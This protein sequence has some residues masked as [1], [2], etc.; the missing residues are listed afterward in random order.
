MSHLRSLAIV[1]GLLVAWP[2]AGEQ[3]AA[4]RLPLA[5][6]WLVKSSVLVAEEGATVSTPTFQP[7]G[8]YP[9]T[10]PA[11]VLSTLIRA[12]V[13]P[14]LRV[15]MNSFKIPDA[16]D[17]FN[18]QHDLGQYSYLPDRRNPW[19]D[20]YW[21]RT[22]FTLPATARGH[23][24]W[25]CFD[26]IHYRADVWL[27][28]HPVATRE[29]VVGAFQ[30]YRFDVTDVARFDG[31]NCLA[32]KIH[33]MDHPGTP[34]TQL[35]PL[36]R[37]RKY[38]KEGMKDVGL[39]M[40]IGYDCMPTVPDRNMGLWQAVYLELG[41][42]VT[43]RDP[44]VVTRLPLPRTDSA[45]LT[46]T[47]E[48]VNATATAQQGLLRGTIEETGG[49][50]EQPITLGPHESRVVRLT[51]DDCPALRLDKPR[52]WWPVNY[53]PQPLYHLQLE[54]ET[55]GR[56]LEQRRVT[57]GVREVRRELHTLD[58]AH[59]LRV[60]VNGQRIFCR[61][62]YLQPEILFDWDARRM[63]TEIRYLTSANINLVYFE[64]IPCPPDLLLD[65]CDRYGLMFGNCFYGCYW[66]MPGKPYPEDLELLG[67]G[68]ADII[69]R[70]RNH[71]SLVL[72]MAM[73]EG[74]TSEKVYTQWRRLITEH[75]GTR[76]WIPSGS[77]PDYRKDVAPWIKPD[78]PVGMN[79][80]PPKS[81]GW[82]GPAQ[83]FRWVREERNWMFMLESGCPAPPP[84]DSLQ[85]FLPDFDQ[86]PA[87][88]LYPLT[89]A[90]AHHDA[91]HYFKPFDAA[92]R[93]LL[94]TPRNVEDYLMKSLLLTA[95]E[96]RGLFEAANHRM[97]DIT[98]GFSEWKLNACWPCVEWQLYDWYLRPLVSYYYVKKAC[99][100]LHVQL[101]PLD[102][103]VTVVNNRLAPQPGLTVQ[104]RVYDFESRLRWDKTARLD[105]PANAYREVFAVPEALRLA[106]VFFVDLKLKD[107]A[108]RVVSDNFYWLAGRE[109]ADLTRIAQLAPVELRTTC[110]VD[111][112]GQECVARVRVKNPTDRLAFFV[113]LALTKGPGGEEVLPVWWDDNY[114]SLPPGASK[115]LC[116][117]FAAA[118]LGAAPATLELGGWNVATR[119]DCR[120]VQLSKAAVGPGEPVTVTATI[121]NTFL[122]GSRIGLYVDDRPTDAQWFWARG[123][124]ARDLQFSLQLPKPGRHRVRVGTQTAELRVE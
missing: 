67:R 117:R 42:P 36:G 90:W 6:D 86:V 87:G 11:T 31:P 79:D 110:Q 18:R 100:P 50:F 29:Q 101:T 96:H 88:P 49:R 40:F 19:R 28:G 30:R 59:G 39:P 27:N 37:D 62:G 53:G 10:V 122:Q 99:E 22:V 111:R 76:L 80:Y 85:R 16:A 121:A 77:Y 81:Y 112:V 63:E 119:Y 97:W 84:I 75:D 4:A 38:H 102:L 12:G 109:P 26:G 7:Q 60:L 23:R 17:E 83:L 24:V 46:V 123:P 52:L 48:L 21:Y 15:G 94:G 47:A 2:A 105:A 74:P 20:P 54:V 98:S 120:R 107:R 44:F 115:E 92:L 72:Y 82:S 35:D 58:G 45:R 61:G 64:D 56:T 104:A 69:R 13:Y 57:F 3:P 114:F 124:R 116:A 32:V 78:T 106:P 118:D 51:A 9:T 108:G 5:K 65:L 33:Q 43:I 93:R 41:G 68:T 73:N 113:H 1:L 55:A 95:D 71:P 70:L 89:P 25:L 14:D 91:C 66:M 34:E 103:T 8:W